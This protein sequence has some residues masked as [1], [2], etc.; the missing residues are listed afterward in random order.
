[1][2]AGS[3]TVEKQRQARM[4]RERATRAGDHAFENIK[5]SLPQGLWKH[6]VEEEET[7]SN[8]PSSKNER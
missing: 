7:K 1:M 5:T 3:V 4:T 2:G 8:R 6:D